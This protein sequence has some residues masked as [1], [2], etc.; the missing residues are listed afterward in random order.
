[1]HFRKASSGFILESFQDFYREVIIQ[2]EFASRSPNQPEFLDKESASSENIDELSLNGGLSERIQRKLRLMLE[3]FALNAQNHVTD[4][5][6]SHFQ[7]ALYIMVSLADEVFL[8][9]E[10]SGKNHWEDHLLEAQFFQTQI[11]G[12]LLFTNLD[13][14]CHANDPVRNEIAVIYLLALSLG[15]RGKYRGMSDHGHIARYRKQLFTMVNRETSNLYFPGRETLIADCYDHN[16]SSPYGRGLPDVRT[17]L[18]VF[19][20]IIGLYLFI[21]S[22]LWYKIAHDLNKSIGQIMHQAQQLGLS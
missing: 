5:A 17:W 21:S 22:T 13:S 2:R 10:W 3:Q 12:E 14:L 9:F 8:S 15:F 18:Y 11:A 1:M 19:A 4:F 7:E 6:T 20:G 16:Q